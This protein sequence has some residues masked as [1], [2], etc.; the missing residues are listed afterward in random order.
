MKIEVG[1]VPWQADLFEFCGAAIHMPG[2]RLLYIKVWKSTWPC[3]NRCPWSIRNDP[4]NLHLIKRG[5][6]NRY[7]FLIANRSSRCN[8]RP[9]LC[10]P[11]T[12]LVVVPCFLTCGRQLWRRSAVKTL[13][14]TRMQVYST[15][16]RLCAAYR[17]A[18][19]TDHIWEVLFFFLQTPVIIKTSNRW[20]ILEGSAHPQELLSSGTAGLCATAGPRLTAAGVLCAQLS[21]GP[22]LQSNERPADHRIH[23]WRPRRWHERL[24]SPRHKEGPSSECPRHW[25]PTKQ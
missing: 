24:T 16:V 25:P 21:R 22:R 8:A 3:E 20:K 15:C 6:I 7:T 17:T 9:R 18:A 2:E 5:F 19:I 11:R 4:P 14:F 10:C 23:L 12:S 13:Q 1:S